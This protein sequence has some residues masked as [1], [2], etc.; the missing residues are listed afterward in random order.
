MSRSRQVKRS[1]K[2]GLPPG[3]LVHLGEKKT[4]RALIWVFDYDGQHYEEKKPEQIEDCLRFKQSPTVTWINIDGLHDVGLIEK[5]GKHFD[6]H[7]LILEDI[8]SIGQRPKFDDSTDLLF[9]VF[10]ML[11]YDD[12]GRSIQSEQVSV[13][14]GPGYVISFQESPGDVFDPIRERIRTGKSRIRAMGA[15]YL[16]YRLMDAVI[17]GYFLILEKLGEQIESL[18]QEVIRNPD[19]QTLKKIYSIKQELIYLRKSVWPLREVISQIEKTSS[20]L[21][22]DA[23][24]LYFRD[25]YD[26]T[27]Q[28]MDSVEMFRDTVSGLLDIYLTSISNR[29]NSIMKVLTIIATIFIPLT[30]IVGIYGMNFKYMPELNQRWA[31]PA[32]WGVMIAVVVGMVV[33][34]KKNKWL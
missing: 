10:N 18:E 19:D 5:I 9:V 14:L 12:T 15:D 29:L 8:L 13:I 17:D 24:E 34:F 23:T 20:P 2:A 16:M 30:F 3:S 22:T 27:I 25:I 6:V 28:V 21:I 26:H 31:Y 1:K 11:S 32:L 33:Y 4:E 7:P